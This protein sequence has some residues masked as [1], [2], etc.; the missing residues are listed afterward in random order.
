VVFLP[1]KR[2]ESRFFTIKKEKPEQ[3]ASEEKDTEEREEETVEEAPEEDKGRA[4]EA[5]EKPEQEAPKEEETEKRE[6]ETV[7]ELVEEAEH[8]RPTIP[9]LREPYTPEHIKEE[10]YRLTGALKTLDGKLDRKEISLEEYAEKSKKLNLMLAN[11]YEKKIKREL[12]IR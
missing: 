10:I 9:K 8:L 2:R 6:E 12:G 5:E 3:E 11:L 7:E 4:L 1:E